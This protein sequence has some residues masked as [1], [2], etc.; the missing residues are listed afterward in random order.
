MGSLEGLHYSDGLLKT[1]VCSGV[2]GWLSATLY[3]APLMQPPEVS[4]TVE[5][6]YSSFDQ[7]DLAYDARGKDST[8]G[9]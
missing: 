2:K 7:V 1:V 5:Q 9:M 4:P 6:W 8:M 3:A